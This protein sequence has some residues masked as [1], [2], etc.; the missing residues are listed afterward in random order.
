MSSPP[1][2]HL[3]ATR[4][5]VASPLTEALN[6]YHRYRPP[7][8]D[9]SPPSLRCYKKVIPTS[10]TLPTT[11]PHLHFA[12]FLDGAP[13]NR[14]STTVI[15]PFHH[16]PMSIVSPHNDTHSDELADPLSLL[17]SLWWGPDHLSRSRAHL[18]WTASPSP[19][20]VHG[21]LTLS[22][23]PQPIHQVHKISNRETIL[24]F[25]ENHR[26]LHLAPYFLEVVYKMKYS[27]KNNDCFYFV[28]IHIQRLH[29]QWFP[30][31]YVLFLLYLFF[32]LL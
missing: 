25:Q 15:I 1:P 21:G 16:W 23:G 20:Q 10:A 17:E 29:Y 9:R 27:L 8:P 11:Q 3:L 24:E 7:S 18:W 6:P 2:L 13:R 31:F 12:S 22:S 28:N 19:S 14:S 30:S 5:H 32:L 26:T 4:C